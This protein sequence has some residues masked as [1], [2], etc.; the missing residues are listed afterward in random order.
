LLDGPVTVSFTAAD[1]ISPV[2]GFCTVKLTLPTCA[3]VDVPAAVRCVA[4]VRV[5]VSALVPNINV[6]PGAKLVPFT[7][8]V[9]ATPLATEVGVTDVM[10]ASGAFSAAESHTS[11]GYHSHAC[12]RSDP[13][14][15]P[16]M[17]PSRFRCV[18]FS[19]TGELPREF[20][21]MD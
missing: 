2:F 9:K 16:G 1:A 12:N 15:S 21:S 19:A 11:R 17:P 18:S 5:V 7:V 3:D 13:D 20:E 6:A 10:V 4:E 14:A 8:S